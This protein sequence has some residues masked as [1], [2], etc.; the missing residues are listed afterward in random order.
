MI[1]RT[2]DLRQ[3]E[4]INIVTAE[5]IGYISDVEMNCDNG[6]VDALIVPIRRGFSGMFGRRKDCIVPWDKIVSI[7][8][9]LVLVSLDTVEVVR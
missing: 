8:R 4:V 6:M 5:R 3:R 1:L 2:T 9:D 7:G